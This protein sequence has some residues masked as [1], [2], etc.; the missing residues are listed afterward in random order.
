MTSL[1]FNIDD[2]ESKM[3]IEPAKIVNPIAID[4]TFNHSGT[5]SYAPSI[6]DIV[7]HF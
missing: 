5:A 7:P 3:H 4:A 1:A 6:R 2:P